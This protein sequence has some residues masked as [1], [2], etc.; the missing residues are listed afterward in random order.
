MSNYV[1]D[2]SIKASKEITKALDKQIDPI[3]IGYELGTG[4]PQTLTARFALVSAHTIRYIGDRYLD[5]RYR[6]SEMTVEEYDALR[7][8]FLARTMLSDFRA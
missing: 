4:L 3:T 8:A 5:N 2:N 6:A 7:W 1:F